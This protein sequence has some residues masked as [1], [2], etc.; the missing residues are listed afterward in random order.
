M[1]DTGR[2]VLI[3]D[4]TE[5]RLVQLGKFAF[6]VLASCQERIEGQ[7]EDEELGLMVNLFAVSLEV[8][9]KR[10][11]EWRVFVRHRVQ[12]KLGKISLHQRRKR[13]LDVLGVDAWADGVFSQV[14]VAQ[15][16]NE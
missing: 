1:N 14:G 10:I 15:E 11:L 7:K 16:K 12:C 5:P 3:N 8:E 13:F 6:T 4:K 2:Q 9:K